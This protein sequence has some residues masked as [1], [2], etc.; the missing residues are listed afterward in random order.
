MAPLS[1]T[2]SDIETEFT[3]MLQ[4]FNIDYINKN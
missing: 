3:Y 2:S 4:I 1:L